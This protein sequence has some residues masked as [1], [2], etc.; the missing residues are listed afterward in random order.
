[1]DKDLTDLLAAWTGGDLPP[2]RAEALRSRLQADEAL[3]RAFAEEI[4]LLGRLRAVQSTEPRWL[5]LED[6][7]GAAR[8]ERDFEAG[9]ME[10]LPPRP[11]RPWRFA[12]A[13]AAVLG[14]AALLWAVARPVPPPAGP[15]LAAAVE[16]EGVE[17]EPGQGQRPERGGVVGRGLLRL[18][19]GY[20]G[21]AF[22]SGVHV[23]LEGPA[24]IELRSADRLH[25]VRGRLRVRAAEEGAGFQV[26]AP[27]ALL[28]D[29]G[30]EFGV[31]VGADGRSETYV[32]EGK[33]EVSALADNGASL[34]SELVGD[35]R[36]VAV[37]AR[38]RRIVASDARPEGFVRARSLLAPPLALRP[39]YP[40]AVL[41]SGPGG[42]WRFETAVDG[43]VPN[44]IAGG[45]PLRRTGE[46][47]L[48]GE[49]NR[50]AVFRESAAPQ[51]FLLA[52]PWTIAPGAD[53]AVELWMASDMSR[54]ATALGLIARTGTPTIDHL[55][56]I[57][58]SSVSTFLAHPPGAIRFL[59]RWPPK[60]SGGVNVFSGSVAPARWHHVVAQK[61]SARM[62]LFVDG[63]RVG[64]AAL[65]SADAAATCEVVVGQLKQVVP[66]T[67]GQARPFVGRIDELAI[68]GRALDPDEI[69]RHVQAR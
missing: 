26:S 21:L 36:A 52:E 29:L 47:A 27:G 20:V 54:H 61:R 11:A 42:Y 48:E 51:H 12:A 15:A 31:N 28:V 9:V 2:E 39:S 10:A 18:R 55:S 38:D 25:C 60:P 14:L 49:G 53:Y 19:R 44:E 6:E 5:R 43:D 64:T 67:V 58:T 37:D 24:E 40:Q 41:A 33:V 46:I 68:Y 13:A 8:P 16:L 32:F 69:R 56:V 34:R 45:P 1:M 17:W 4:A 63:A 62:E 30:T 50:S 23:H 22:F 57:E 7:L 59:H 35:R 65:D 3:R 66:A